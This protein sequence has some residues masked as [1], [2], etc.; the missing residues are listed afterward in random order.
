MIL[1]VHHLVQTRARGWSA[2]SLDAP[3]HRWRML[4]AWLYRG[5]RS[6]AVFRTTNPVGGGSGIRKVVQDG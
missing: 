3:G 1:L 4:I 5:A 6:R 2:L